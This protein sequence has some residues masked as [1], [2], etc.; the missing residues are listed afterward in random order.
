MSWLDPVPEIKKPS[1]PGFCCPRPPQFWF[2]YL[3]NVLFSSVLVHGVALVALVA[4]WLWQ[5]R[6]VS[7]FPSWMWVCEIV[8]L[9]VSFGLG[10]VFT[11]HYVISWRQ[12]YAKLSSK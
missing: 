6:A 5:S 3:V 4:R 1:A 8:L 11:Y 9:L 10:R 12:R 2:V 7:F